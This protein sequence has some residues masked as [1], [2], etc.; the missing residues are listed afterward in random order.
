[1]NASSPCS[2]WTHTYPHAPILK[3]SFGAADSRKIERTDELDCVVCSRLL[4]EPVTTT[5][6]HTFCKSCLERS[7]DHSQRCPLCRTV[8]YL[9]P[10]SLCVSTTLKAILQKNFE[11]EYRERAEESAVCFTD[12]SKILP[13]FVLDVV[14][15]RQQIALRIFEPR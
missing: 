8:L 6:G 11:A 2:C 4:Y 13:L 7:V 3:L 15:P 10:G 1:M 5:C 14:L 9:C 12:Q